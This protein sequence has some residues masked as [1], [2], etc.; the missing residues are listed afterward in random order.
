MRRRIK[1]LAAMLAVASALVIT[2]VASSRRAPSADHDLTGTSAP[3]QVPHTI[4]F[5]PWGPDQSTIDATKSVL[6]KHPALLPYLKG[7]RTRLLAFE[8]VE[9]AVKTD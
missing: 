2:S 4:K 3:N 5:T 6:L 8:F 9:S 1:G 7:K